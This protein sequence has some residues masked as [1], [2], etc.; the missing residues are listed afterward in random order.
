MKDFYKELAKDAGFCLWGDEAWNPGDVIDW[1]SRYDQEL[2]AFADALIRHVAGRA[3]EAAYIVEGEG[4]KEHL[5]K[6]YEVPLPDSYVVQ[7]QEDGE[8]DCF[9]ELPSGLMDKMGWGEGTRLNWKDNGDG[10]Y[11]LTADA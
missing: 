5:C 11:M 3:G 6:L 8:G 7:V 10:S 1:S 4:L 2:E 9:I